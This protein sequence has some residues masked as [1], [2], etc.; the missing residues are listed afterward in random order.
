[1]NRSTAAKELAVPGEGILSQGL[2]QSVSNLV[3]GADGHNLDD[4]L[5]DVLAKVV[6]ADVDMLGAR[7]KFRETCKLQC[8]GVVFKHFAVDNRLI[9]NYLVTALAHFI[10]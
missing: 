8:A 6:V 1:M 2:G 4:A 9:A 3:V 5:A 10:Q 7:T